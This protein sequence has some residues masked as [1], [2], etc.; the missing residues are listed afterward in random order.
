[1]SKLT[2]TQDS[3]LCIYVLLQSVETWDVYGVHF[4]KKVN[5]DILWIRDPRTIFLGSSITFVPS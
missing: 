5:L 1:M 4:N 2:E 3:L